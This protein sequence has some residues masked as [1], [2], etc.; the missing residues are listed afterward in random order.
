M[1]YLLQRLKVD[2]LYNPFRDIEMEVVPILAEIQHWGMGFQRSVCNHHQNIVENTLQALEAQAHREVGKQFSLTAPLELSHILF[3]E[4]NLPCS[5]ELVSKKSV[6]SNKPPRKSTSAQVLQQI[7]HLHPLPGIILEHRKLTTWRI[8]YM[9]N[10]PKYAVYNPWLDMDRIHAIQLHTQ[11]PTGRLAVKN[12]NL[13][14]IPHTLDFTTHGI[15]S[16][17]T[18][19]ISIRDAFEASSGCVLLSADYSQLE[20]RLMT[21]FSQ[22]PLLLSIFRKGGD[23]F[24]SLASEWLK[25]PISQVTPEERNHVSSFHD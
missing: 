10:L 6:K 3:N 23:V 25:K 1:S 18:V 17:E 19:T 4:L 14:C 24:K 2:I 7:R 8:K 13:Q 9:N 11:T 21:H 20:V 16:Q 22:D 15:H 12:P 5:K